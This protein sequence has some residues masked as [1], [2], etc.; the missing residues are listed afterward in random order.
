MRRTVVVVSALTSLITSGDAVAQ[1]PV[2]IVGGTLIDGRGGE[3]LRDAAVVITADRITAVGPAATTPVPAGAH[4]IRADG[5]TVLPGLID[6]HMHIGGSGGGSAL[7]EEFTPQAAANSFKSYLM[8]GVTTVFDMAGN[9]LLEA[10]KAA[11]AAGQLLGPRLFGVKYGITAPDAHPMLLLREYGIHEML[12]PV[13]PQV[14]TVDAARAAV[15]RVAADRTDGLKL[16]HSRAEFPGTSRYDADKDKF[17]PDV[18]RALVE[19]G[20]A[21]GLRVFVHAS[22]PSEAR[23]AVLAGVD[24]LA[25]S[26][27]TAETGTEEIFALMAERRVSYIPTLATIEGYYS[28]KVDPFWLERPAIMARVWEPIRRSLTVPKS[29]VRARMEMPGLAED[30]RRSLEICLANLRRAVRAGVP[31]VM[32]T[33]AG[34]AGTLHGATVLRE[35]ALMHAGGMTPMDVLVAATRSAAKAIG[36]SERLGT[37]EAGKLADLIVVAGDPLH[38][39]ARMADLELV[40]KNGA[41]IDPRGIRFE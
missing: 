12:G 41:P 8:F 27:S 19:E 23:E 26:I 11:L 22:F 15:R 20:K 32:G 39:L 7:P 14:D 21:H 28:L 5:K 36:Q 2:A 17:K 25:H 30:A 35:L 24:T 10:Q 37:V 4:V 29:V 3:P 31:I 33:D 38:D 34:N 6:A 16:F 9:P 18:L 1:T 40:V 13:Y